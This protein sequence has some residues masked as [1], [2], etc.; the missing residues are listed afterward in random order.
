M[1]AVDPRGA[2]AVLCDV[3]RHGG[4]TA[5]VGALIALGQ[6]SLITP[7]G[8]DTFKES[9]GEPDL[10][11]RS[12]ALR[13]LRRLGGASSPH[14]DE[15]SRIADQ[16]V[17]SRNPYRRE[18]CLALMRL[19]ALPGFADRCRQALHDPDPIVRARANHELAYI[20]SHR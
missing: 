20:H 15:V 10:R 9:L 6:V 4:T 17:E 12:A 13:S 11:V 1:I 16:G 19:A 18:I 3:A 8:R 7:D 5:R 14:R 2:C